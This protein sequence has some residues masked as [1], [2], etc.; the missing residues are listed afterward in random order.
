[1]YT[2]HIIEITN[3]QTKPRGQDDS[4]FNPKNSTDPPH[5][6]NRKSVRF[7]PDTLGI[8]REKYVKTPPPKHGLQDYDENLNFS[9][10]NGDIQIQLPVIKFDSK[11]G[12]KKPH[13]TVKP[14]LAT[15]P[16]VTPLRYTDLDQPER[17]CKRRRDEKKGKH[18][19]NYLPASC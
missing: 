2:Y 18:N 19:S 5:D 8:A 1:M 3:T 12:T 13:N 10:N 14:V 7:A 15:F 17:P 4:G 11:L 16:K 9:N 6:G